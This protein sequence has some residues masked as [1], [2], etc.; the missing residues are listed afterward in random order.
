VHRETAQNTAQGE[1]KAATPLETGARKRA[2]AEKQ[3]AA[4][5]KAARGEALTEQDRERQQRLAAEQEQDVGDRR[6]LAECLNS[7]MGLLT[8]DQVQRVANAVQGTNKGP[9]EALRGLITQLVA[10]GEGNPQASSA[11]VGQAAESAVQTLVA[12][13]RRAKERQ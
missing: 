7:G 1:E 2:D 6:D 12:N 8:R 4:E 3:R 5:A 13:A 10:L 11:E 9:M